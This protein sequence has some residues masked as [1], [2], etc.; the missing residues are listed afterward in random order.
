MQ[1]ENSVADRGIGW[2]RVLMLSVR[3]SAAA[4]VVAIVGTSSAS[5]AQT[6][7]SPRAT[8]QNGAKVSLS[9]NQWNTFVADVTV[10]ATH[11][12]SDG[13]PLGTPA[14]PMQYQW[15]RSQSGAGWKTVMTIAE[16]TITLGSGKSQ[17]T[18]TNPFA[19]ARIEDDEDGS[20][21]RMYGRNG[22][23]L[24]PPSIDQLQQWTEAGLRQLSPDKAAVVRSLEPRSDRP[25]LPTVSRPFVGGAERGWI[26]GFVA[27]QEQ[28]AARRTRL[29]QQFVRTGQIRGLDRFTKTD[30]D[31]THEVLADP[32]SAVALE[33]NTLQGGQLLSHS[34]ISYQPDADG[35]LVRRAVHVE[36]L[37]SPAGERAVTDTEYAN[38]RVERRR[39]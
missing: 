38:V 28:R 5:L 9:S 4:L 29:A 33:V 24:Q 25:A 18:V 3:V 27:T 34:T 7:G 21:L 37:L 1:T 14:A 11:V 22:R 8:T 13:T 39:Q 16:R 17:Q 6:G 20:P 32:Q 19:V 31:R 26:G 30:G 23:R 36:Q 10:R 35:V 12:T 15:E 2:V